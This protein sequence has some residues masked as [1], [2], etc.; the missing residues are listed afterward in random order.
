[1]AAGGEPLR[2][3]LCWHQLC[4]CQRLGLPL[5]TRWHTRASGGH[6]ATGTLYTL[7]DRLG[8]TLAVVGSSGTA[9][10]S[11]TYD[12]FGAVTASTGSQA[13]EFQ[14]AGEQTDPSGL[15]YLRAR[16]YDPA[17]G[18]FLSRDGRS[19]GD[20]TGHHPYSYGGNN[21]AL[22][23]D[24]SGQ[25]FINTYDPNGLC[26]CY[27]TGAWD[28]STGATVSYGNASDQ[29]CNCSTPTAGTAA[30]AGLTYLQTIPGAFVQ[31]DA[32]GV[33]YAAI[34]DSYP[35]AGNPQVRLGGGGVD[36]AQILFDTL[37]VTATRFI[38]L[39]TDFGPGLQAY[40]PASGGTCQPC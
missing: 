11:Y 23:S 3:E 40:V 14:F 18:R 37:T 20:P 13:T 1:M 16:Y 15:Q 22:N 33:F 38:E 24:P 31:Y 35:S 25:D 28:S 21:P 36:A 30:T 6:S 39:T 5:C 26:P 10:K 17:I 9:V 12:A 27:A 8:S 19:F 34:R 2:D 4:R 32:P 7:A 29:S